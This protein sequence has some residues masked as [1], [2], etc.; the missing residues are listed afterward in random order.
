[1]GFVVDGKALVLL[2]VLLRWL[3]SGTPLAI[4][5]VSDHPTLISC[6]C[7]PLTTSAAPAYKLL[8]LLQRPPKTSFEGAALALLEG[9][10]HEHSKRAVLSLA[11]IQRRRACH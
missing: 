2:S 7:Q 3:W 8:V 6:R 1:M 11:S 5:V 9:S 10:F 4:Q